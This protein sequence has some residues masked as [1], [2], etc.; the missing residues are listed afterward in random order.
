MARLKRRP[1]FLTKTDPGVEWDQD[2]IGASGRR[3]Q[4]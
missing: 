3:W 2:R 4:T 1:A